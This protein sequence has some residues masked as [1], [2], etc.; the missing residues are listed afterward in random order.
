M[1][2]LLILS[3]IFFLH[4]CAEKQSF[5]KEEELSDFFQKKEVTIAV[6]DSGLG[7]LSVLADASEKVADEL[8]ALSPS[9]QEETL[10]QYWQANRTKFRVP[11]PAPPAGEEE[12]SQQQF[13][14]PKFDEV[15]EKV[16]DVWQRQESRQKAAL[17]LAEAKR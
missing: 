5:T 7:G 8:A 15:I 2:F 9:Q 6:I 14:D 1:V 10:H 13:R 4:S 16:R 17:L 11:I 3:G 12:P